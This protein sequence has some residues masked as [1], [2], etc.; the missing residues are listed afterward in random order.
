MACDLCGAAATVSPEAVNQ[1]TRR[2]RYGGHY[3]CMAC[4]LQLRG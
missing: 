1:V 4:T 2:A 3:S